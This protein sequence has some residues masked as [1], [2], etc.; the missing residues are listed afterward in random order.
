MIMGDFDY[1][2]YMFFRSLRAEMRKQ[3]LNKHT[4]SVTHSVTST[5]TSNGIHYINLLLYGGRGKNSWKKEVI[6]S[7]S[8]ALGSFYEV[9]DD[10]FPFIVSLVRKLPKN[11]REYLEQ[12]GEFAQAGGNLIWR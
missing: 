8:P 11:T 1:K 6:L 2:N 7:T 5:D 4:F 9:F 3:Y 12:I 10:D